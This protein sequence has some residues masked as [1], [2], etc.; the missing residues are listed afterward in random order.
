M[1]FYV[2]AYQNSNVVVVE[3]TYFLGTLTGLAYGNW[4]IWPHMIGYEGL[5]LVEFSKIIKKYAHKINRGE[6]V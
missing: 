2:K 1:R 5:P 6:E 4:S 3:A